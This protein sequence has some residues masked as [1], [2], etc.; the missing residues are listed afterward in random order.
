MTSFAGEVRRV[1]IVRDHDDRFAELF[2]QARQQGE[3]ILRRGGIQIAGE[4]ESRPAGPI[5]LKRVADPPVSN[6]LAGSGP[7]S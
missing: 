1:R 3:D 5:L 4:Q 6:F 7:A 2:V